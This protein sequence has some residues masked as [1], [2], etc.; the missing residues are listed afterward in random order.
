[1]AKPRR[2]E[3][4]LVQISAGHIGLYGLDK[5]GGVWQ[6]FAAKEEM[7]VKKYSGWYRLTARGWDATGPMDP[8]GSEGDVDDY[9]AE[10]RL[11]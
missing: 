11:K 8:M 2:V 3:V 6:Y 1:M 10:R 5:S 7:G 9:E 4:A